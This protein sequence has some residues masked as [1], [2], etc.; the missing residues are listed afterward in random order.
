[1]PERAEAIGVADVGRFVLELCALAGLAWWGATL[2]ASL[3]VRIVVA[4]CAPLAA[5]AVWGR[6]VA[7][8]APHALSGAPKLAV[9]V[10][11]FAAATAALVAGG[12]WPLGVAL[13][14]AYV[15]DSL[16]LA[17]TAR[18]RRSPQA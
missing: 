16:A 9:E 10:G 12:A 18:R 14:L 6:Y 3:V 7:P 5:A 17:A 8:R 1:M 13:A 4:V 2:D 11:V 15:V